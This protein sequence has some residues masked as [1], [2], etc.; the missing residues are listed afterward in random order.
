MIRGFVFVGLFLWSVVSSGQQK[1]Y[2]EYLEKYQHIA[3]AEMHRTGIP[4]S[5]KMAQALIESNAGR[6]E[7]AT[8]ANNHFG[9]KCGGDWT[10]KSFHKED[11]DYDANGKLKKSC[12]RHFGS[13]EESF[14]AHSEFLRNPAKVNRYGFLFNLPTTDYAA[15][16][17]G[18]K[19][20]G[21]ATNP[22]Y[23][24]ILIRVI[25][26]YKL[27]LLDVEVSPADKPELAIKKEHVEQQAAKYKLPEKVVKNNG[28][29]MVFAKAGDTPQRIADRTG[30][31][32]DRILASNE[33]LSAANQALVY[34]ER[35]YL[36]TKKRHLRGSKA[37]WHYVQKGETIYAIAQHYGLKLESLMKRNRLKAGEEPAIG[38]RISINQSVKRSDKPILRDQTPTIL[39][40]KPTEK[41]KDP[42]R[43]QGSAS[44]ETAQVNMRT[45]KEHVV[46]TGDTLYNISRKYGVDIDVI[47]QLNQLDNDQI[48]IG[49]VLRIP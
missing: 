13:V 31:R 4:A 45:A 9:I 35:V 42:D 44:S 26:E 22:N 25:E 46:G 3:V 38:T 34:G 1:A 6:S 24:K 8:Q 36:S 43:P 19:K 20:A 40:D 16:A 17:E 5:V 12:F 41:G 39:P 30:V 47:K 29:P 37:K 7:L 15:W 21:Y 14:V 33:Q 2:L 23:A 32:L 11:D 48:R 18:L 27:H 28:V 10:G 49:Q